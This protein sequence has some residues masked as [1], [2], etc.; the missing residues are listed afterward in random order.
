MIRINKMT[1][2]ISYTKNDTFKLTIYPKYEG[3]FEAGSQLRFVIAQTEKS[4]YIIDKTININDDL[5][6]TITLT[7]DEKSKLNLGD[8]L[9][10]M[11]V[12]KNN[13]IVTQMSGYFNVKWGA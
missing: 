5:T 2:D 10:K 1:G 7:N 4:E 9:Y 12:I 6:F 8:Y 11:I 13:T 3:A